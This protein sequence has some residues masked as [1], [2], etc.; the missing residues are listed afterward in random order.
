[1]AP[2]VLLHRTHSLLDLAPI[3]VFLSSRTTSH[4]CRLI[5]VQLP[6]STW[7]AIRKCRI[8]AG[9][10]IQSAANS[11]IR[12]ISLS[13]QTRVFPLSHCLWVIIN[14]SPRME[15]GKLSE[16][17]GMDYLQ[18]NPYKDLAFDIL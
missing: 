13:L 6:Q 12:E 10:D 17:I 3:V 15:D 1:M 11:E 8:T 5:R 4:A 7:N 2:N 16:Q 14:G 18:G 9:V